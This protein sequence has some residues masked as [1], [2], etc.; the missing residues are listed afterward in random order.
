MHNNKKVTKAALIQ[1]FKPPT[2]DENTKLCQAYNQ[3]KTKL[4]EMLDKMAPEKIIK[5][6]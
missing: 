3:L 4:K 5:V 1:N 2:I 6:S